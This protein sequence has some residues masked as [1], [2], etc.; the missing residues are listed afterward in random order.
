VPWQ[1]FYQFRSVTLVCVS[2]CGSWNN[3]NCRKRFAVPLEFLS[4]SQQFALSAN[5]VV[6]FWLPA[7]STQRYVF[8]FLQR[9]SYFSAGIAVSSRF[10]C[11][12]VTQF[13]GTPRTGIIRSTVEVIGSVWGDVFTSVF[14]WSGVSQP[15]G[16]RPVP[17]PD[18]NYPGPREGWR[19]YSMLQ[20]FISPVHN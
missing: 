12:K 4:V 14:V 10:D 5:T 9:V 2:V 17:G 8:F 1:P 3:F 19:N 18:I 20:D 6:V 11:L 15:T 16:R 13:L 7:F